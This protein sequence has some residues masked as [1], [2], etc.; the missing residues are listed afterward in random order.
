MLDKQLPRVGI[1]EHVEQ[2]R[3]L[4]AGVVAVDRARGVELPTSVAVAH[5]EEDRVVDA[6]R[7]ES[8]RDEEPHNLEEERV[9]VGARR[10]RKDRGDEAEDGN[11]LE[12]RL[13]KVAVVNVAQLVDHPQSEEHEKGC[14]N[15]NHEHDKLSVCVNGK[16][17]VLSVTGVRGAVYSNFVPRP[18]HTHTTPRDTLTILNVPIKSTSVPRESGT[19]EHI[20]SKHTVGFHTHIRLAD[21][22]PYEHH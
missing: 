6:E 1:L 3:L 10:R 16:I 7:E 14:R 19:F 15:K 11:V 17:K 18:S 22:I 12:L 8:R 21:M 2:R 4:S 5:G 20:P 13:D 9:A